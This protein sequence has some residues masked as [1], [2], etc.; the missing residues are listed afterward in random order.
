MLRTLICSANYTTF[1]GLVCVS[2]IYI[3]HM[4]MC[5]YF[6]ILVGISKLHGVLISIDVSSVPSGIVQ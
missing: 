1:W 6:P 4:S 3:M 2:F 5:A